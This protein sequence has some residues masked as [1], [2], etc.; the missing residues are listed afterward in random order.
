LDAYKFP[1]MSMIIHP[2]GTVLHSINANVILERA[3]QQAEASSKFLD[4][5]SDHLNPSND[6]T[7]SS[8]NPIDS[9]YF[10]FLKEPFKNIV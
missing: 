3:N 1:V 10:E 4:K 2:N 9:I 7:T 8:M 5:I 6:L